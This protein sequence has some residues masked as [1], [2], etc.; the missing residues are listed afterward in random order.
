MLILLI[1]TGIHRITFGNAPYLAFR[2]VLVNIS[3][4]NSGHAGI[5]RTGFDDGVFQDQGAG[6]DDGIA[7]DYRIVHDDGAHADQHMIVNRATVYDGIVGNGH[8]TSDIHRR[9]FVG[10][11][12]NGAILH[13][14]MIANAY[15]VHIAAYNGIVPN[16]AL[17]AHHH[18]ANDHS[19][20]GGE[21][22]LSEPGGD[23]VQGFY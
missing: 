13:I 1:P 2:K 21:E 5:Y 16:A 14:H 11:M 4:L 9:H 23:I 22:I 18:I 17:V 8:I 3:D 15:V 19:R 6:S 7:F 10:T 20:F 12:D